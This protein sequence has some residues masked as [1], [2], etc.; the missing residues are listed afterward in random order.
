MFYL[1]DSS[2]LFL[3]IIPINNF[4]ML[5]VKSLFLKIISITTPT[6]KM[7]PV[8]SAPNAGEWRRVPIH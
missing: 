7:A 2:P 6:I 3:K 8:I 4:T 1:S 5:S